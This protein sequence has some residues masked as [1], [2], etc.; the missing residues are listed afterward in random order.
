MLVMRNPVEWVLFGAVVVLLLF[1][2]V[3]GIRGGPYWPRPTACPPHPPKRK[4]PPG[5]TSE[6]R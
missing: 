6:Q 1:G 5:P 2:L 3:E 4:A